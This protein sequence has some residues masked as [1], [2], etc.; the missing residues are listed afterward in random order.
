MKIEN[1]Q[2]W[3]DASSQQRDWYGNGRVVRLV[4][5]QQAKWEYGHKWCGNPYMHSLSITIA[6]Q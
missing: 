5:M 2:I 6:M 3:M 4:G 1:L